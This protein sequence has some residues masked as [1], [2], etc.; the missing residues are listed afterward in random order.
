MNF[1]AHRQLTAVATTLP[2]FIDNSC[3]RS[4]LLLTMNL[5]FDSSQKHCVATAYVGRH[6]A[7]RGE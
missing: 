7:W 2:L 1:S 6:F 4:M 5:S 3:G